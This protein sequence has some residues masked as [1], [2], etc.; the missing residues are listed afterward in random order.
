MNVSMVVVTGDKRESDEE[1]PRDDTYLR[2]T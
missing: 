1:E 2:N